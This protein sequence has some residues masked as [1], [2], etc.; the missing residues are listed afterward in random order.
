[1]QASIPEAVRRAYPADEALGRGVR[2][3]EE[4][5][6]CS[7]AQAAEQRPRLPAD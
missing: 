1:M 2:G 6:V 3:S 5:G 7:E 4:L